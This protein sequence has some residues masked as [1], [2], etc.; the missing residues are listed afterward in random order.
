VTAER[1]ARSP[2]A[3]RALDLARIGVAELP[4]LAQVD[5]RCRRQ[6]AERLG[7]PLEPNTAGGDV[8]RSVLWLGPDE[9]LV[10]GPPGTGAETTAEL[11]VALHGE[12]RSVL[13]VSASR[14]VAEMT[15]DDRRDLLASACSLDLDAR[16]WRAGMC[17]QTLLG[18]APVILHELPAATRVFVRSSFAGYLADLL[19]D[20]AG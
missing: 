2:L 15:G 3:D 18:R 13:D 4:F 7:F 20:A 10:V 17:A 6:A 9:W 14:G 16:A 19:V 8:R 12:H 1:V 11:Q 5:V